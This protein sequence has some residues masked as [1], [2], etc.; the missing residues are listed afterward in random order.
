M[1][2]H[3]QRNF[4]GLPR[5]SPVVILVIKEVSMLSELELYK[6]N[7]EVLVSQYAEKILAY[8]MERYKA[9]TIAGR[10]HEPAH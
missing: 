2:Q 6:Q 9:S 4:K 1:R 5:L 8:G 10:E 3:R 7:Q